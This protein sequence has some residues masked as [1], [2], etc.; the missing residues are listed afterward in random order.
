MVVQDGLNQFLPAFY[1][2]RTSLTSAAGKR[3]WEQFTG[4]EVLMWQLQSVQLMLHITE[5]GQ[6]NAN[7]P[8][9]MSIKYAMQCVW[10]IFIFIY[11]VHGILGIILTFFLHFYELKINQINSDNNEHCLWTS[12][13]NIKVFK[14][15][16]IAIK[17]IMILYLYFSN[18]ISTKL[19][20]MLLDS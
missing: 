5:N 20:L 1:D 6:K 16:V 10:K 14:I 2:P 13:W 18:S 8:L 17:W 12:I 15:M 4:N 11:G 9:I 19:K 7:K 3:R